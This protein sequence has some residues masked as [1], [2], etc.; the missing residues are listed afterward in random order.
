MPTL[1]IQLPN[2][3]CENAKRLASQ[4]GVSVDQFVSSA[5]AE[6]LAALDTDATW[7]NA[8]GWAAMWTST[9]SSQRCPQS[10]RLLKTGCRGDNEA[11]SVSWLNRSG[12]SAAAL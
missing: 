7:A 12:S 1:T 6:K 8:P 11:G 2:S 10:N 3:I 9:P 4:E 5:I